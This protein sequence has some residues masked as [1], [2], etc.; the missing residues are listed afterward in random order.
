MSRRF[1]ALLTAIVLG[2][3][4][5]GSES[6]AERPSDEE[7]RPKVDSEYFWDGGMIPF[8]YGTGALAL[9][10]RLFAEPPNTPLLFPVSEGGEA[11]GGDT[12]PEFAVAMYSLGFAGLIAAMPQASRW[13]HLKGYGEALVSTAAAT[14]V[15]KN[16][17]GR[18]RPIYLES[19]DDDLYTRRSFFSG[20]ASITAA[21]TVYLG[22]YLSRNVLPRPSLLKT[23]GV[24]ALGGLL[25]AVPYSRVV[26]NRHHPSDVITGAAVGSAIATVFYVYQEGR[27]QDEKESFLHKKR[28]R[29]RIVPDLRNPGIAL[30]GRW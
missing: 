9:G 8:F 28:N 13:H 2:L 11:D 23:A 30:M 29:I 10:I 15:A 5:A 6:L 17:F 16:V 25:V 12:V 4:G 22:L 27:F 14:E 26:D 1:L 21:S 3:M 24:L 20:H 18:R 19:T 7:F